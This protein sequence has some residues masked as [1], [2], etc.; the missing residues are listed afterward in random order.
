MGRDNRHITTIWL[1]MLAKS[2]AINY[3]DL[4]LTI[5]ILRHVTVIILV[6]ILMMEWKH[7]RI[8][9]ISTMLLKCPSISHT[10]LV[11]ALICLLQ[12]TVVILGGML[13]ILQVAS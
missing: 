11:I 10:D 5:I 3:A 6:A 2:P 9:I 7:H 13:V 1:T 8:P 4:V 12:D